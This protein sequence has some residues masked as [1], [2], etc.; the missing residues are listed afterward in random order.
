MPC[1]SPSKSGPAVSSVVSRCLQLPHLHFYR[2]VHKMLSL[3]CSQPVT[4]PGRVT[5]AGPFLP[6][7]DSPNSHLCSGAAFWPKTFSGLFCILRP[8]K[9]SFLSF[10][11]LGLDLH[12]SLKPFSVPRSSIS[13]RYILYKSLTFLMLS[14]CL[15]PYLTNSNTRASNSFQILCF[16]KNLREDLIK[17]STPQ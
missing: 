2:D 9:P 13:C 10:H 5:R 7:P 6:T 11:L 4:E 17:L 3:G 14:W 1:R 16:Q 8:F 15:C 12:C